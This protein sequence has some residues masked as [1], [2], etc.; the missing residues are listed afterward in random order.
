MRQYVSNYQLISMTIGLFSTCLF[1][2]SANAKD[3]LQPEGCFDQGWYCWLVDDSLSDADSK[4]DT[5]EPVPDYADR[6]KYAPLSC[7][8]MGWDCS[9]PIGG[10]DLPAIPSSIW[11]YIAQQLTQFEQVRLD[12]C[13]SVA[14]PGVVQRMVNWLQTNAPMSAIARVNVGK[15]RVTVHFANGVLLQLDAPHTCRPAKN[16][17]F[18]SQVHAHIWEPFGQVGDYRRTV[19]WDNG[20]SVGVTSWS[21]RVYPL[22]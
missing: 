21:R 19:A 1:P 12:G 4:D 8:D 11:T 14:V 5:F 7:A 20:P 22:N 16:A 10:S 17:P 15:G 2:L 6:Q 9:A 3:A 13:G 18:A